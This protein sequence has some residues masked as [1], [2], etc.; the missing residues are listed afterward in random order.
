MNLRC[1]PRKPVNKSSPSVKRMVSGWM[2]VFVGVFSL[3]CRG[4]LFRPGP[5]D[6][7]ACYDTCAIATTFSARAGVKTCQWRSASSGISIT[8]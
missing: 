6:P 8:R 2:S 5:I 4:L 3:S 1:D 7:Q